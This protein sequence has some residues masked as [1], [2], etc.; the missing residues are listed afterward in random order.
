MF[1]QIIKSIKTNPKKLFLIDGLGAI[2]S[3]FLLGIVLVKLERFFGIPSSTLY[4]LAILPIFF[5]VYDFY[6]FR[7]VKTELSKFLKGIAVMNLLYCCLSIGFA[8]Y[9]S[10]TLTNL[11]WSYLILEILIVITLAIVELRVANRLN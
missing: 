6:S 5:A 1:S 7:K 9:H 8:F 2:M 10:A 11:G 4:I 3:A